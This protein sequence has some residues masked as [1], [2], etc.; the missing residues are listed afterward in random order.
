M[1]AIMS[2]LILG[3]FFSTKYLRNKIREKKERKA[4]I[5][6]HEMEEIYNLTKFDE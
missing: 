1:L 4:E 5:L 3:L 2:I 6:V